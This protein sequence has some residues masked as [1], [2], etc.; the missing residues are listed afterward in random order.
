MNKNKKKIFST[1]IKTKPGSIAFSCLVGAA[2]LTLSAG[3]VAYA[4]YSEFKEL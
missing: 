2:I 3:T 4:L 1:I